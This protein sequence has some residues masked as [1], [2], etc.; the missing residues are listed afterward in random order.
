[1]PFSDDI[2]PPS[3][4]ASVGPVVAESRCCSVGLH[5]HL[6]AFS[7]SVRYAA[8][9]GY[10]PNDEK[11]ID[12]ALGGPIITP[13]HRKFVGYPVGNAILRGEFD[14]NGRG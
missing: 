7:S 11:N 2:G 13:N 8:P 12:L 5:R 3:S 10:F 6:N 9:L 4:R 14:S 1:M